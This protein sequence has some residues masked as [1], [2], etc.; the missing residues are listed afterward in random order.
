MEKCFKISSFVFCAEE[1]QSYRFGLTWGWMNN[2]IFNF[3]LHYP[4]MIFTFQTIKWVEQ[5]HKTYIWRS[6]PSQNVIETWVGSCDLG[7]YVTTLQQ[8]P[9]HCQTQAERCHTVCLESPVLLKR[10]TG[11][12]KH[13]DL[14]FRN[15]KSIIK[16]SLLRHDT[17]PSVTPH[18]T[19]NSVNSSTDVLSR[20]P[21]DRARVAAAVIPSRLWFGSRSC[22]CVCVCVCRCCKQ[23]TAISSNCYFCH[24]LSSGHHTRS[25]T[26]RVLNY[27]ADQRGGV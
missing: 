6:D 10:D 26:R 13:A 4:F 8:T 2:D 12:V 7:Q 25:Q 3:C 16:A 21:A 20:C 15:R 11:L 14:I 1:R 24:S 18:S 5:S 19:V 27:T 17:A 22:V 23:P 9:W